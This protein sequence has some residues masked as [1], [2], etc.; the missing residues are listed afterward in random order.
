VQNAISIFGFK[1]AGA[2]RKLGDVVAGHVV[3]HV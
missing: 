2:D 1:G 3:M